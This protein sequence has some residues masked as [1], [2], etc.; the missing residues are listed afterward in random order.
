[1]SGFTARSTA[2]WSGCARRPAPSEAQALADQLL[3]A[4]WRDIGPTGEKIRW[5]RFSAP[6]PTASSTRARAASRARHRVRKAS[7]RSPWAAARSSPGRRDRA[8]R[9]KLFVRRLRKAARHR[10]PTS[11]TYTALICCTP[12]VEKMGRSASFEV[13]YLT[14]NEP[15]G[16][17]AGRRDEE[18]PRGRRE[19]ARPHREGPLPGPAEGRRGLPTLPHLLYLPRRSALKIWSVAFSG[20]PAALRLTLLRARSRSWGSNQRF[21]HEVH[22]RTPARLRSHPTSPC[23][24]QSRMTR[25][26]WFVASLN[27]TDGAGR[28]TL[29]F[30]EDVDGP[31]QCRRL[32]RGAAP[33][34]GR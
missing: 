26:R 6:P 12:S 9:W 21:P 34:L 31:L 24:R 20:F 22:R 5:S 32:G 11:V 3:D 10:G 28:R 30:L 25:L 19:G 1:M 7:C 18:P 8:R 17:H 13:Q 29:V 2:C 4:A 15:V 16:D 23:S 14:T 27:H 33:A